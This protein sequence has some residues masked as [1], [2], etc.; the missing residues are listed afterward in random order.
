MRRTTTVPVHVELLTLPLGNT[1][2]FKQDS[3]APGAPSQGDRGLLP[4]V[5]LPVRQRPGRRQ[6]QYGPVGFAVA[7][8]PDPPRWDGPERSPGAQNAPDS[9]KSLKV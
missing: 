7:Q 5:R 8:G 6:S 3:Y 9:L 1:V 4:A 2:E